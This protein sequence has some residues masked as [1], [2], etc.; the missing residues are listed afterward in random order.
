MAQKKVVR[1]VLST[2]G[3]LISNGSEGVQLAAA[4]FNTQPVSD[5][6]LSAATE[7]GSCSSIFY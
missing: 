5:E 3:R 2:R 7:L 4:A 6:G 1:S